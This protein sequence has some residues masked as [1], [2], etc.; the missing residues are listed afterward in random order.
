MSLSK[1]LYAEERRQAILRQV[2]EAGRVVVTELSRQLGV[3]EVTIRAD[4]Q[5]LADQ[6]LVVRT[7]G[8]AIPGSGSGLDLALTRRQQ[9]QIAEK[10]RIGRAAAGWVSDGDA[11]FL[12][13]SSSVLAMLP[14]LKSRRQLTVITNSLPVAQDLCTAVGLKVVMPGGT[15]QPETASLIGVSGLEPL[16]HLNIQKGFFG[17]HGLSVAEGLTDVSAEDAEF[18]RQIVAMCRQKVA[19]LDATK[20]GRVGLAA[21][22]AVTDF[23]AVLTDTAAPAELVQQVQ[24]LNVDVVLL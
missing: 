13:S 19:L 22:A 7:H 5:A 2:N 15:L 18:K 20:W 9:Q 4:L 16:R 21:F 1:E 23:D 11:V 6:N 10:N 24:N 17:A 8:G 14:H 3:S 12:D